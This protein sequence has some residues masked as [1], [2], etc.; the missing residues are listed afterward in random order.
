MCPIDSKLHECTLK[1][2]DDDAITYDLLT[3]YRSITPNTVILSTTWYNKYGFF[4]DA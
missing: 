4:M 2:R 1:T 3:T